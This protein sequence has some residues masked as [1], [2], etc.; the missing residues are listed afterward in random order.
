MP[1]VSSP[2][3]VSPSPLV[4][5]PPHAGTNM[6]AMIRSRSSLNLECKRLTSGPAT[7]G[8]PKWLLVDADSFDP[9]AIRGKPGVAALVV[10]DRDAAEARSHDEDSV[11]ANRGEQLRVVGPGDRA[12]VVQRHV[13]PHGRRP[14]VALVS[15]EHE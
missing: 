7:P 12:R 4:S 11:D 1:P 2:V 14:G 9:C 10:L 13:E 3:P 6:S 5:S 8:K 15:S